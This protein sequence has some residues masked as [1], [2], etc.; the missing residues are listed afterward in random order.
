MLIKDVE[1][2][3]KWVKT[4]VFSFLALSLTQ[5]AAGQSHDPFIVD[6]PDPVKS[7]KLFPNPASDYLSIKF[8]SPVAK[9]VKVTVHN[10]I[11]N[12][13]E[14]DNEVIDDY[15]LHLKVKELPEGVYFLSIK[16][17]TNTQASF[18][19]LKR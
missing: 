16:D 11:G 2:D 7:A 4:I 15:E 1:V 18:K 12:L 6:R 19:F 8:E 17:D 3:M 5:F 13:L 10:I 9:M 14:V